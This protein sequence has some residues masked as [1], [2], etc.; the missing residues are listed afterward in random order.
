MVSTI[1]EDGTACYGLGD[2]VPTGREPEDYYCP[3]EITTSFIT[4]DSFKKCGYLFELSGDAESSAEAY[5]YAE[6]MKRAIRL[7][8]F[9]TKTLTMMSETQTAQAMAL[10][11]GILSGDQEKGAAQVLVDIIHKDNDHMRLGVLGGRILFHVLSKYGCTDLAYKMITQST[12]PSYGNWVA[13]GATTLW[14][15]FYEEGTKISSLNHHFRGDIS[16]WFISSLGGICYNPDCNNPY[17]VNICPHFLKTLTHAEAYHL[18]PVGKISSK[19]RRNGEKI[20]LYITVPEHT[21]GKIVVSDGYAFE[22]GKTEMPLLG[23]KYLLVK[24]EKR[25]EKRY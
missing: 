13:R 4:M 22:N 3:L 20:I 24:D 23:G 8:Y 19:W 25:N 1:R 6:K 18:S 10:Y 5:K 14:E 9:D 17:T 11:F 15:E 12:Y 7:K 21:F 16:H 2:F